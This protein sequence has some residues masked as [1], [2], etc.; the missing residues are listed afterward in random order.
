[1]QGLK[2]SKWAFLEEVAADIADNISKRITL[3]TLLFVSNEPIQS[4]IQIRFI[5]PNTSLSS[6]PYVLL[7]RSEQDY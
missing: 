6:Q 1:M 3:T 4:V 2:D 7:A 5:S